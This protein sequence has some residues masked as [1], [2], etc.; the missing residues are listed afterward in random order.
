MD[1]VS[2]EQM[3]GE[4]LSL[5]EIA[6]RFHLHESTVGYWVSKHN[7]QAARRDKHASKGGLS[8]EYLDRLVRGGASIAEIAEAVG[9]SKATVRHWLREYDLKTCRSE[10]RRQKVADRDVALAD[11]VTRE[12]PRHGTTEF[13]RRTPS[14]YRCLKCRSEAVTERRRRVKQILVEDA[15]GACRICGYQTC[16]G[17]LEFH[18]VDRTDKRFSLSHRG[19]A[20]SLDKARAEAKK[21]VLLCANCHV[22]VEAGIVTLPVRDNAA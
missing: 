1:R 14:G 13:K 3:L 17:A 6:R 22:E 21:C 19:V 12:C 5:A 7:L 10:Q 11:V 16:I 9:R 20:R 15:G 18:H 4:G 2:L 8:R